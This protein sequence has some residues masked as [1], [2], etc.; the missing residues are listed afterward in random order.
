MAL[1][2]QVE[3]SATLAQLMSKF[4]HHTTK[5]SDSSLF[6]KNIN[7][8]KIGEN[9]NI[10]LISSYISETYLSIFSCSFSSTLASAGHCLHMLDVYQKCPIVVLVNDYDVWSSVFNHMIRL[11]IYDPRQAK[12][13][14]VIICLEASKIRGMFVFWV[15]LSPIPELHQL[16]QMG[17]DRTSEGTR[18]T[19]CRF[20]E[21]IRNVKLT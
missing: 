1:T 6:D 18:R 13:S 15:I 16:L 3:V 7:L 14:Q 20:F 9:G 2:I 8:S 4:Q 19:P 17:R 5:L 21:T 10:W 11:A 12:T